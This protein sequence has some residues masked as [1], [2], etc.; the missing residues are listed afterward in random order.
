[1]DT[2]KFLSILISL[3]MIVACVSFTASADEN[4][5]TIN[6]RTENLL[7]KGQLEEGTYNVGDDIT[8]LLHKKDVALADLTPAD[9]G[10]INQTKI[11]SDGSYYYKFKFTDGTITDTS[12]ADYT[13]STKIGKNDITNSVVSATTQSIFAGDIKL[14]SVNGN[15]LVIGKDTVAKL[16]ATLENYYDDAAVLAGVFAFY[17]VKGNLID[18]KHIPL[19]FGYNTSS[20]DATCNIPSKTSKIKCFVWTDLIS[21]KPVTK[22]VENDAS[23]YGD[24]A[25]IFLIGDSLGEAGKVDGNQAG[26]AEIYYGT[27]FSQ[28]W[29]YYFLEGSGTNA[30]YYDNAVIHP[31]AK[32]GWN[33]DNFLNKQSYSNYFDPYPNIAKEISDVLAS[34]P[35]AKIYVVFSLGTNDAYWDGTNYQM[36]LNEHYQD[37]LNKF[38]NGYALIDEN[39]VTTAEGIAAEAEGKDVEYIKGTKELGAE[40]IFI[41]PAAPVKQV[42]ECIYLQNAG[43]AM[44]AVADAN[45]GVYFVDTFNES[46]EEF[47][48]NLGQQGARDKYFK[49]FVAYEKYYGEGGTYTD[50]DSSGN[51]TQDDR[52]IGADGTDLGKIDYLHYNAYGAEYI[53]KL[54]MRALAESDS[55]IKYYIT[56]YPYSNAWVSDNKLR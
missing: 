44:K 18:A 19:N 49:S 33:T 1:M 24:M 14:T 11:N 36:V 43:K 10:Y 3:A 8:L 41:S 16:T 15:S 7:I 48:N 34:N 39:H 5:I 46:Y 13:L 38:V 42:S 40:L 37:N 20:D 25:H 12:L 26:G 27:R 55:S 17:D 4:I 56:D 47:Y 6:S 22:A 32:A 28:G 51:V 50:N 30:F 52:Y 23:N 35:N 9:V 53:S 21:L 31:H 2:K 29:N 54:F 45:E